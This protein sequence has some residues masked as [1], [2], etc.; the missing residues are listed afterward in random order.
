MSTITQEIT[1]LQTAKANLK[2]S[3]EAK[4]VTVSADA[5]LDSYPA[6]VDSIPSGGGRVVEKDVNFYDYDGTCLYSYTKQ[7][8]LA[9]SEM[10]TLPDHTDEGLVSDEWTGTLA[11]AKNVVS[12]CGFCDLGACFYPSD[13]KSSIY[14]HL[15]Q[16]DLD[17][18]LAVCNLVSGKTLYVDWGDNTEVSTTTTYNSLTT[19]T[20][21]YSNTGDFIIKV[22]SDNSAYTFGTWSS[23]THLPTN[24]RSKSYLVHT[25]KKIIFGDYFLINRQKCRYVA[26]DLNCPII[27]NKNMSANLDVDTNVFNDFKYKYICFPKFISDVVTNKIILYCL[28]SVYASIVTIPLSISNVSFPSIAQIFHD[29]KNT[30]SKFI[31]PEG[32][33]SFNTS[34]QP[35]YGLTPKYVV[36]P[37]TF[38]DL[39]AAASGWII[40][41]SLIGLYFLSETPPTI[42]SNTLSDGGNGFGFKIFVPS[43][44]VETYKTAENWSNYASKIQAFP[45]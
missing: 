4:G 17:Y 1:R 13:G 43:S 6:L 15:E 33:Q 14:I 18:E 35:F 11:E 29:E 39:S 38:T 16:S 21:T 36:F 30:V 28:Y 3:L 12:K 40:W 2:T 27:F 41:N 24:N 8:F 20:H 22:Y 31:I 26:A 7:E 5:T 37:T 10:P 34:S 19:L 42:S 45:E 23:G 9:L 32:F 44:A 25:I